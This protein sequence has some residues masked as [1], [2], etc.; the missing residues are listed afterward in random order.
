MAP[1]TTDFRTVAVDTT[2]ARVFHTY[3][4]IPPQ[5]DDSDAI[6]VTRPA[7]LTQGERDIPKLSRAEQQTTSC[8]VDVDACSWECCADVTRIQYPLVLDARPN[9]RHALLCS[10]ALRQVCVC[11]QILAEGNFCFERSRRVP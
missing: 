9:D 3:R 1:Y 4:S 5:G 8:E 7:D 2:V 6:D 10:N 11:V